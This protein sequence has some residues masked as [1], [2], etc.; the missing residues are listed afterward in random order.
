MC[1]S[2]LAGVEPRGQAR[3][4]KRANAAEQAACRQWLA[5]ELLKVKPRLVVA[6]GAMAAQAL[7]GASFRITRQRGR[8]LPLSADAAGIATWHPSFVLRARDAQARERTYAELV[9]DLRLVA[10]RLAAG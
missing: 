5:A 7:F 1:S 9:A 3:L 6:M 10:A 8:W 2:D 4:H